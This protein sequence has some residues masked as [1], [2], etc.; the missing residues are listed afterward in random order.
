MAVY[1]DGELQ[2][3]SHNFSFSDAL[4]FIAS[5]EPEFHIEVTS[6]YLEDE[7]SFPNLLY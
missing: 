7:V 5:M 3:Q 1:V 2:M 6:E 4:H